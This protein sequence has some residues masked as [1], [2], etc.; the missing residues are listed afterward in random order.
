MHD[1]AFTR[2]TRCHAITL[3][4]VMLFGIYFL[5]QTTALAQ[6]VL[7]AGKAVKVHSGPSLNSKRIAGLKAGDKVTLSSPRG[8]GTYAAPRNGFFQVQYGEGE[9]GWVFGN[10]LYV[11]DIE[12]RTINETG[13]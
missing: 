10:Y 7:T 5:L 11:P 12:T 2:I 3:Q 6:V 9:S 13:A 1:D 8:R 4:C